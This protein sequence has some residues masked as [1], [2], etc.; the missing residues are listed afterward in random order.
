MPSSALNPPP[1]LADLERRPPP[2]GPAIPSTPQHPAFGQSALRQRR[3]RSNSHSSHDSHDSHGSHSSHSSHS[4]YARRHPDRVPPKAA[5][6]NGAFLS[7]LAILSLV[8]AYTLVGLWIFIKG[9]LLTRHELT[10]VNECAKPF[11]PSWSLPVPPWSFDDALLLQWAETSL[12]PQT[13]AGECRLAPTHKKAVVLI[14]DA[15]R[16]D[17]IA[18]PPPPSS[19]AAQGVEDGWT[20]NPYYHNILS[21]PSQLTTR[22]GIPANANKPGPSSFIAHFTADPPTTTL[23][24][25]K[26]LTTGTLPTFIE[27]GANFGSAGTGV[28]QVNEDH[29]IAQFKASILA[30]SGK[31]EGGNAGLVFAGDDTWSTVF[32]GL[33]D[34]DKMWTYDSF[35]VEDLDTVDRGVET[36]LLPFLQQNHP[37]RT[38]GVHDD[39]RLLIGHTLGVDHV[40][41]R[42]GANHPKMKVKLEEVQAF[43]KDIIE[44]IDDETL[45]VLM[46]DH[47]MD[48]RG[49][50][51]GDAELEVGAGLWMYSKSGFGYTARK[52]HFDPAEYI[53]GS[54]VEALLPS[55]IPFSPLPSPPYPSSGHRSVPQIDLVPTISILLGLPIPYNNL[56]SIIPDLFP[57]PDTLL[58]TL[59]ITAKQMRTYLTT[60]AKHSPDL[61]AFSREFDTVWLDAVRADAELAALL[62]GGKRMEEV[63]KA[64]RKA[65]QAYHRFNRVSLMKAR[66]VWAQFDM[67]RILVGLVVLVLGLAVI[68][69]L[70]SGAQDGLLGVLPIAAQQNDENGEATTETRKEKRRSKGTQ[71]LLSIVL[72]SIT[73]PAQIGTAVGVAVSQASYLLPLI[74]SLPKFGVIESTLASATIASQLS[75]LYDH[76]PQTLVSGKK[77]GEG[78]VPNTTKVLNVA[79]Y[80]ILAIHAGLFA[81]NSFLINEDR[82]ILLSLSTL[83]TLRGLRCIGSCPTTRGKI[84]SAIITLLSLLLVRLASISKVCR[85][86]QAPNCKSTFFSTEALNSPYLMI[87]SYLFAYLLPTLLAKFLGQSKS[88]VG[89]APLFFNF[90]LRPTLMLGSGYWLLDWVIPQDFVVESGWGERLDWLKGWVAKVDL[91]LLCVL[92]LLFWIFA[93][94]CLEIRQEPA[95]TASPEREENK[96]KVTIRGYANSLGSSYLLLVGIVVSLLWL[97]TQPA[98]QLSLAAVVLAA[99]LALELGDAER[100]T[101]ILHDQKHNPSSPIRP[102][103]LSSSEIAT[104]TLLSHLAFFSTGHQAT[105]A[106]IQWRV[107]FL[108]SPVLSYPLSPLL[109]LLNCFGQLTLLPPLLTVL[110]VLWNSTPQPRGSAKKMFTPQHILAALLTTTLYNTVLLLSLGALSALVFRRHLMLFKLWTPRFLMASVAGVMVQLGGLAA[111]T[112]GWQVSN[113]VNNVFGSEFQ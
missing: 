1:T 16:Y 66:E 21:V 112:A 12:N 17:F 73:R 39:W 61:A 55:R 76:L 52:Q 82:F 26:G 109:V 75:L 30:Q 74:S 45:L 56:G 7:V 42:F 46:G 83:I 79:G 87:A 8:L 86:E 18:S 53:S 4:S 51:G 24:R 14:V 113:K 10:G 13:G 106:T 80:V 50:H 64:W 20:P 49:D 36:R 25:L 105:L 63:E 2:A 99:M 9:F 103:H 40:G 22:Y 102:P 27:A 41:H 58:R 15:L 57:H 90:G 77:E 70:K 5:S 35:N 67:V 31:N 88:F 29:W 78:D 71:E 98:G 97:V 47:G 92:G 59:R 38:A 28:G 43:L 33:F 85:E 48:E 96:P 37:N 23:Q 94:L 108:T 100:D 3:N 62:Q 19:S 65:A 107:A 91:V 69:M 11:D 6:P 32:P 104:L 84:R 93:P 34:S 60:Y 95:N 54:E 111:A 81:S 68:W 72:Q 89:I 110:S 101:L 44:A